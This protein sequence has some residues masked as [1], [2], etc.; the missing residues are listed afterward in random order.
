MPTLTSYPQS[1]D[2][3]ATVCAWISGTRAGSRLARICANSPGISSMRAVADFSRCVAVVGQ[4][5]NAARVFALHADQIGDAMH[6]HPRLARTRPGQH[7]H[8]RLF[9]IIAHDLGL[10]RVIQRINDC[11]P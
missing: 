6:Q 2:D 3:W 10:H 9:A 8:V 7:Q 4:H 1:D 11:P 5:Q